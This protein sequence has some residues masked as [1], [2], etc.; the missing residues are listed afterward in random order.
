VRSNRFTTPLALIALSPW[1]GVVPAAAQPCGTIATFADG[2]F[3]TSELHVSTSGSNTTGN[4]SAASPYATIAFAAAR[5]APGTAIRVHSG[6]YAGGE[7]ITALAGT[8]AAPIW[9]GGAPGEVRPVIQGGSDGL[10]LVRPRYVVVQDLE[11][12]SASGNGINCDDGGLTG[13]PDAARFMIFRG[14]W[15]HDIGGTG[16]Q[17]GLKLSG[18]NDFVVLDSAFA[19]CGGAMSGSG[20]DHVGCH[21]G[22]IARC[23]FSDL[24]ANAV[25]CKGGSD[26]LEVRWCRMVEAGERAV[27]MGG[28]TGFE[29]F[30]PPLSETSP[31]FEARNIRVMSNIIVGSTAPIAYVGCVD[32]LVS[33]NT[34]ITPHNWIIRI[35][36]ET[37][38]TPPYIFEPC[39]G[40]R[41]E[42]N[43]VYFERADLSTYVNIGSNTAPATF[44]FASN[45]WYA[46]DNPGASAPGLPVPQTGAVIGQDP[47]MFD[48]GD[49]NYAIGP[50][51]PAYRAGSAPSAAAGDIAGVCYAA[52]PSIG[53]YEA[54]YANCDGSTA[55]PALNINDFLCFIGR[56]SAGSPYANC[57]GSTGVPALTIND[58]ICFQGRYA[59]G[60]P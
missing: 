55:N 4:G 17:D 32:C 22:L 1:V 21:R 36:Q 51:S 59:S 40:G 24:S 39:R 37:V 52:P 33:G 8:A 49:S 10:H 28:S 23:L 45:L 20:I 47:M 60:C 42:N 27:N 38:S 35:L 11:V 46:F 56:F 34:I 30:R 3:P 12:R 54:C 18:L 26:D 5:A 53:A 6:T 31:N 25:Q 7:F 57:D 48:P 13:D 58:F 43:L 2:L 50:S 41:F 15:I 14:L 44:E 29:F 16:N 19:R 9:L